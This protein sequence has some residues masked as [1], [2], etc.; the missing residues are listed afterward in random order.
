MKFLNFLDSDGKKVKRYQ[1]TAIDD[2]S[3]ARALKIY[4]RHNQANAVK[5][6]NYSTQKFPIRIHTIQ[7]DK[8]EFYQLVDYKDDID[9]AQKLTE[10]QNFYNCHRPNAAQKGKTPYEVLKEKLSLNNTS[11]LFV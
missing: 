7:T 8:V 11:F 10:W 9:I 3:R 2:A 4:N 1:Y 6:V 5:F